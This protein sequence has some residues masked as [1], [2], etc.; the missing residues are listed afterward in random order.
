MGEAT[1]GQKLAFLRTAVQ[2][3]LDGNFPNPRQCQPDKCVHGVWYWHSCENCVDEY[4][5]KAMEMTK[6]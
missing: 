3:V 6:P 2:N 1:D 4:L 5:A